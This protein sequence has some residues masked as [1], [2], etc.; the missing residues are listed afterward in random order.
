MIA[1]QVF[2]HDHTIAESMTSE[3]ARG[4]VSHH[5]RFHIVRKGIDYVNR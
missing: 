5:P 4:A 2:G 3:S 1:L